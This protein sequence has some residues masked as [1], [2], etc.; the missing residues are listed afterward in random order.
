VDLIKRPDVQEPEGRTERGRR[1]D[2]AV[3]ANAEEVGEEALAKLEA[4]AG[5]GE[6]AT[7]RI[8]RRRS[9]VGSWGTSCAAWRRQPHSVP[10][11]GHR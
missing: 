3:D 8:T 9:V 1:L 2:A 6:G 5:A 10:R 7:T 4:W 11:G